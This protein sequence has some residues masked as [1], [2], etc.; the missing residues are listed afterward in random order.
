MH[1]IILIADAFDNEILGG[2]ELY[3]AELINCLTKNNFEIEKIKSIDVTAEFLLQNKEKFFIVANFMFLNEMMKNTLSSQGFSYLILEHDHKYCKSNNP[4]L[5]DNLVVPEEQIIN[6]QF[7]QKARAVCCQ[8]KLH[9]ET[10]QKN[11]LL[12]N[13]INLGCNLWSEEF[14]AVLEE[15]IGKQKTKKFGIMQTNNKNKGME[16]AI[17]YCRKEKIQYEFIPFCRP[18]EF[19]KELAKTETLIFFPQWMETFCRV[20]VEA[21]ILGC[22]LITNKSLG[23]ASESF[24]SLK[25]KELLD[26]VRKKKNDIVETFIKIIK[27]E[28]VAFLNELKLPKVTVVSTIYGAGEHIKGFMESYVNQTMLENSELI[29]IDANSPDNEKQCIDEYVAKY[30]NNIKYVRCDS[31]IP[32]SEANN[33]AIAMATGE[34]IAICLVDDRLA[35]DYLETLSKHLHFNPDVDLVYGD[36]LQTTKANETMEQNSSRGRMY[37]HSKMDFSRENMIKCLP[38]PVPM[39]RKSLHEKNGLWNNKLKHACDWEF[40]LRC[41]RNGSI[42]K[43]IHKPV[44]LYFFNPKGLSTTTDSDTMLRRRREEKEVF[45]EFKDV[46]GEKNYETFKSYFNSVE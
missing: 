40:W 39:Y 7:Y 15:N 14:L 31:R 21:R 11:L 42:F 16:E 37:E 9:A 8:S 24:F 19:V 34:F 27:N 4:I 13:I 23:C 25:G 28:K 41:V 30:P 18:Q 26:A 17:K 6:K 36:C 33:M 46:I 44:G 3:N 22:K 38:G 10:V 43:K 45:N 5:F 2:A 29:I 1:K 12:K 20:A 32:G 35:K